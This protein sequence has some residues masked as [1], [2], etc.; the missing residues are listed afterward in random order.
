MGRVEGFSSPSGHPLSALCTA[1]LAVPRFL[2]AH[3]KMYSKHT[4]NHFFDSVLVPFISHAP[5]LRLRFALF[6]RPFGKLIFIRTTIKVVLHQKKK[7]VST[8]NFVLRRKL[9]PQSRLGTGGGGGWFVISRPQGM[10]ST[11]W[12]L[13]LLIGFSPF[14]ALILF[15]SSTAKLWRLRLL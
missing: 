13:F 1:I 6:G 8:E 9:L 11:V 4:P 7:I 3:Q 14:F 2:R 15:L 10:S 5:S 12:D